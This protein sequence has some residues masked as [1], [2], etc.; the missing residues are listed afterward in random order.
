MGVKLRERPGKGWYVL[1]DWKGQRKAKC[2]GKNKRLAQAFADKLAARLSW[3]EHNGEP[4]A[5]SQPDQNMPTVKTCLEDWLQTYAQVHCK[6]STY[7]GYKRAITQHLIPAFGE[8]PLHLLKRDEIKRLIARQ[9]ETR[10][11]GGLFK[12]TLS[13]SRLHTTKPK[14]T[15][16]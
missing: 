5:L 3:A 7:R 4:L 9:I 16:S 14:R 8:R 12:T 15:G 1:T 2:F 13:R 6:P 11:R 10:R